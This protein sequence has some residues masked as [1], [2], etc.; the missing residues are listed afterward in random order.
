MAEV[1]KKLSEYTT[2]S[3]N[4]T[5][6]E[7]ELM[8]SVD[9]QSATGYS[10]RKI[11]SINKAQE[12]LN[13]FL[14]PLLLQ[15]TSKS[16]IGAINELKQASSSVLTGTVAPTSSQGEDGNLYVQYTAGTGGASDV[17]DAFFVKLDGEW[18]EISTGGGTGGTGKKLTGTLTA[19]STS[20]TF[21][22]SAITTTSL[23]DVYTETGITPTSYSV[24]AGSLS[25]TFAS[26][27]ADVGIAVLID[28]RGSGS[29]GSVVTITPSQQSGDKVADYSIDGVSGS[30]YAQI[31]YVFT[32]D[33]ENPNAVK[34][35]TGQWDSGVVESLK[36]GHDAAIPFPSATTIGSTS[37]PAN[38]CARIICTSKLAAVFAVLV[39]SDMKYLKVSFSG[40]NVTVL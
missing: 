1:D 37:I 25:L 20:V 15:T 22:D 7:L 24:S 28:A 3:G 12:Y 16:I 31:P 36:G 27:Q 38:S 34:I 21:S 18:I 30:L 19:G 39:G 9:Q 33:A 40:G 17:V 10:S 8:A 5:G 23:I 35:T 14:Y 6:N 26:Q 32:L 4:M 13:T 29:G 11:T 2:F